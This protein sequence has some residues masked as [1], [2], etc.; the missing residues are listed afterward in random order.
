MTLNL[1]RCL[2]RN[3]RLRRTRLIRCAPMLNAGGGQILLQPLQTIRLPRA[4]VGRA[5]LI[6][7]RGSLLRPVRWISASASMKPA[8]RRHQ[9]SAKRPQQ[10]FA[11]HLLHHRVPC[12]D[13][14]AKHATAIFDIPFHLNQGQSPLQSCRLALHIAQRPVAFADPLQ[15]ASAGSPQ[16]GP[17]ARFRQRQLR[18]YSNSQ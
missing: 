17:Y 11:S 2:Q 3:P 16:P 14:S 12:W 1:R 18:G 6:S 7:S 4:L 9:H 15:L 13:S 10:I 5:G 8:G